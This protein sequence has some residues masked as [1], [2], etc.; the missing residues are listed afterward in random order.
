M[1]FMDDPFRDGRGLGGREV[2]PRLAEAAEV[3][4]HGRC[5]DLDDRGLGRRTARLP[6]GWLGCIVRA[7][8]PAGRS[9]DL[10]DTAWVALARATG[11]LLE[12]AQRGLADDDRAG[13]REALDRRP[14][15]RARDVGPQ[16]LTAEIA[17]VG[18]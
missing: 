15:V 6:Q 13:G 3:D 2:L 9:I 10:R 18:P 14:V 1:A 17:R 7:A 4:G 8:V 16:R 5:H 12:I 11:F